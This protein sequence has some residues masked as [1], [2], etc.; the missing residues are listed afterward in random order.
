MTRDRYWRA[1]RTEGEWPGRWLLGGLRASHPRPGT[2]RSA[3]APRGSQSI[4]NSGVKT[5]EPRVTQMLVRGNPV[6]VARL[7]DSPREAGAEQQAT[8]L[9][10]RLPGQGCS[11]SSSSGQAARI[12]TVS[13]E[14]PMA[15]RTHDGAG[16]TWTY[17]LLLPPRRSRRRRVQQRSTRVS[18]WGSPA[19]HESHL[20]ITLD[21]GAPLRRVFWCWMNSPGWRAV[22][23]RRLSGGAGV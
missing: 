16:K 15:A 13:G 12:S 7:L 4:L 22:S 5:G 17:G 8:A 10:D 6:G 1:E 23:P 14:R 18:P 21:I 20:S 11:S 3:P 19:G 2:P 9:A